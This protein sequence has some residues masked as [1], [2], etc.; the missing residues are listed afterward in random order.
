MAPRYDFFAVVVKSLMQN[1]KS[2]IVKFTIL[3]S[4][5]PN[6]IPSL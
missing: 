4:K 6:L 1:L 5:I 3:S 2:S